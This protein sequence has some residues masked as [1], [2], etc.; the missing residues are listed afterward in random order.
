MYLSFNH[1]LEVMK[2]T[3]YIDVIAY[4]P[5]FTKRVLYLTLRKNRVL[6]KKGCFI[7]RQNQRFRSKKGCFYLQ[8]PRK[9][10]VFQTWVR[11][12]YTLWSG[13]GGG[14]VRSAPSH[15]FNQWWLIMVN[16]TTRNKIQ[17]NLKQNTIVQFKK[18]ISICRLQTGDHLLRPQ[19]V[20]IRI[21]SS[22][23]VTQELKWFEQLHT[24]ISWLWHIT[25]MFVT[26]PT[27][28]YV[29]SQSRDVDD[30]VVN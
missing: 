29:I 22:S 18:Y 27:L 23:S 6:L 15:C 19:S 26:K 3:T 21:H 25:K 12:C 7:G 2:N 10:G 13:V 11:A 16:W 14:D 17:W 4:I 30:Y 1:N 8:N 5:T 24:C 28:C 20:K 9:G